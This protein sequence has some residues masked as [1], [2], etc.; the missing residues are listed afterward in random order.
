MIMNIDRVWLLMAPQDVPEHWTDRAQKM[1]LVPL[2][3]DE[4]VKLLEASVAGPDKSADEW[5]DALTPAE[6]KVVDLAAEG[7][8]N[9]E[10]GARLFISPRTVSTHLEH[11]FRK[12]GV[13]SRVE[14]ASLA[15]RRR[16]Q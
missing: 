7:L 11:A 12:L 4:T 2:S 3:S 15:A 14:L 1:L 9:P 13:S 6:S 16:P 10:I 8:T 5:W